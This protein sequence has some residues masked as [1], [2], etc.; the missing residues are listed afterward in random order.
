MWGRGHL[1]TTHAGD[2]TPTT[3]TPA[4]ALVD[5][6]GRQ[7]REGALARAHRQEVRQ[8]VDLI[9]QVGVRQHD[10]LRQMQMGADG[11]GGWR[12][13]GWHA[14][15]GTRQVVDAAKLWMQ[16]PASRWS[17]WHCQR[18]VPHSNAAAAAASS[19]LLA[20]GL[21]VVPEV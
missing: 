15:S 5:V 7:Q 19:R 16:Q 14:A 9:Q 4:G 18:P 1:P 11:Q 13:G 10:A 17:Q 20:L 3:H 2:S 6:P 12:R 21:P 8:V